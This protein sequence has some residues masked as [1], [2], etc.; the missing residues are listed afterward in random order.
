MNANMQFG[1]G[2]LVADPAW[3]PGE[4]PNFLF[5][6][7]EEGGCKYVALYVCTLTPIECTSLM[8]CRV[9]G[10]G[11]RKVRATLTSTFPS[12]L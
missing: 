4:E 8:S 12:C 6:I 10:T 7:G 11:F 5:I 1:R 3:N 2:S 9:Y